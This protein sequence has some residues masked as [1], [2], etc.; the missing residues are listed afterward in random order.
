MSQRGAARLPAARRRRQ[1]LDVALRV[2]AAQGFDGTSMSEL[3]ETAGVTKPVVYQHFGSKRD[4]Y[5]ELLDDVGRHLQDSVTKAIAGAS[6]PRA[7]VQAGFRAYFRFVAENR[8]AFRLLFMGSTRHDREF[9]GAVERVEESMADAIAPLIEAGIDERHRGQLAHAL[10]GMAEVTGRRA[11]ADPG[12]AGG[13][14]RQPFDQLSERL[15]EMA[16]AGLRG[17]RPDRA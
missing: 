16:W 6:G 17:I 12:F 5:L 2:F 15:S 13:G 8:D 9:A 1:L 10:V 3:A 14:A 11:M 7:Q 4:L